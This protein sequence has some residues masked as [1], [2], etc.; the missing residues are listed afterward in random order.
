MAKKRSTKA[1]AKETPARAAAGEPDGVGVSP[2][3]VAARAYEI[4]LA[5]GGE[6]RGIS[7]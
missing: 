3:R 5:R 4:Y 6:P 1:K 7:G 2:E